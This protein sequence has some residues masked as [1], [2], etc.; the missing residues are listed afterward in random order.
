MGADIYEK[1]ASA[2]EVIDASDEAVGGGLKKLM[3]EGPLNELT[4]T[5]NAQPAILCHSIALLNVLEKDYAFDVRTCTY[6]LGHSLGEYTA[7]VATKSL[8]LPDALRLVRLRGQAMQRSIENREQATTMKALIINGDH[9]EDVEKLMRKIQMSM[10]EGEV[11]EIANINSRSQLVLSGTTKGV[12]YACS[13]IQTR[14]LAGRALTLPVSAPFHCSLMLPAA[15]EM[16]SA[17]AQTK[18]AEPAIEVVSNV[19]GRPITPSDSESDNPRTIEGAI[20]HLLHAQMTR[21]VQWQRS[22]R[23][24]KDDDVHDWI[25]VGPSRVLANLLRKEYGTDEV[26]P[27][28]GVED[29]AGWGKR[30]RGLGWGAE[31]RRVGRA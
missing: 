13:I 12:S 8:S 6:A 5:E 3:F 11:A 4:S 19:T 27:V 14:S 18:F 21:T 16:L 20:R 25:V 1:Y 2:R 7:L 26:L 10:P 28:A 23:F 9:L 31:G 22:T 24:C 17:L 15:D 30:E 29:L